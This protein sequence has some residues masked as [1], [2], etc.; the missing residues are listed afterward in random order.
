MDARK[1][2]DA[3]NAEHQQKIEQQRR[4]QE[5]LQRVQLEQKMK[6]PH[7]PFNRSFLP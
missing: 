3:L 5:L 1:Q 4:E 6:V 2:F 7:Q